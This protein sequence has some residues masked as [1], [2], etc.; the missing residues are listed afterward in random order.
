MIRLHITPTSWVRLGEKARQ[1]P[2]PPSKDRNTDTD[3]CMCVHL[4]MP[5]ESSTMGLISTIDASYLMNRLYSLTMVSAASFTSAG[6]KPIF[7]ATCRQ[8]YFVKNKSAASY[9]QT[10]GRE[11]H[12][13]SH[14]QGVKHKARGPK[15]AK[16]KT[17]LWL[18]RMWRRNFILL[19]SQHLLHSHIKVIK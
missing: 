9:F 8:I 2:A 12:V 4:P 10:N 14:D 7:W 18:W 15:L 5:E 17:L 11:M 1:D 6:G 3:R 19:G 13:Y 16:E